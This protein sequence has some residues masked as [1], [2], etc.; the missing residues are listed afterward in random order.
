MTA[1]RRLIDD[2]S[3]DPALRDVLR[4]AP[5]ARGLDVST[6]RRLGSRVARASAVPA[7]A[8]GW[9]FVKSAAA[10]AAVVLGTG[11]IMIST[12]VV[13]WPSAQPAPVASAV[14]KPLRAAPSVAATPVT[15]TPEPLVTDVAEPEVAVPAAP[16]TPSAAPE[17]ST[18]SLAAEAALLEQ[19]RREMR[20]DAN[21]ALAIA[22]EH[23]V[24]FPKGQLG[25]ERTLIQIEALHRLHRDDEARAR[26]KRLLGGANAEL[27]AE[28]IRALLGES[29]AP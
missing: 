13:S 21:M 16:V 10:A 26:A 24:R 19:A 22:D 6:R 15:P 23:R 25:S 7:V 9:L 3:A 8:V 18:R 14:S 17:A 5:S 11:T 4:Q 27:Y 1:P 28:R 2:D 12:G 20:R 29:A